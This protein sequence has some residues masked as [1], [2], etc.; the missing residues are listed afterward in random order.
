MAKCCLC[1]NE[2]DGIGNNPYPLVDAETCENGARCCDEC[3]KSVLMARIV[4]LDIRKA[5]AINS[6]LEK[7][8]KALAES[9][10]N[11]TK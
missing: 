10:D 6:K 11:D 3:D 4:L 9:K 5:I 7:T 8:K 1:G 2:Y